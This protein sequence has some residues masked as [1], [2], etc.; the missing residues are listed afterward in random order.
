MAAYVY[1]VSI[2]DIR[3][4]EIEKLGGVAHDV[5]QSL[6]VTNTG[7]FSGTKPITETAMGLIITAFN[8]ARG[9]YKQGGTG[10]KKDY[11]EAHTAIIDCL[12]SLAPYVDEIADGDKVILTLSNLPF[13]KGPNQTGVKI[14]N[15]EVP[16]VLEYTVGLVGKAN[17]TCAYF[18]PGAKYFAVISR[19]LLPE[20]TVMSLDG[21]ILFPD[22]ITMPA[23]FI[24]INGK[25][26]KVVVGMTPRVS[27]YLY[28]IVSYGGFVSGLSL[29]LEIVCGG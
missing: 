19:G 27:Y 21:Q 10:A 14:K 9:I 15:G 18:G 25:R 20:G 13:T 6:F 28:Y 5:Q 3:T 26:D 12:I 1:K 16:T 2:T 7:T 23:F 17:V 4:I 8:D 24:N 29:P 22:G 11:D